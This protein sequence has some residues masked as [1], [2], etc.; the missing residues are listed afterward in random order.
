MAH[1]VA[2]WLLVRW[3]CQYLSRMP[4]G[5]GD[6]KGPLYFCLLSSMSNIYIYIYIYKKVACPNVTDYLVVGFYA[7]NKSRQK[8]S[9]Q[10]TSYMP[11]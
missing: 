11:T 4:A 9:A 1:N 6:V 8:L 5:D 7:L 3:A 10:M 2:K